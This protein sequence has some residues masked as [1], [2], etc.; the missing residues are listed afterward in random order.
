M[1]SQKHRNT[2]NHNNKHLNN[3]LNMQIKEFDFDSFKEVCKKVALSFKWI[4]LGIVMGL[5][6][7]TIGTGFYY[8]IRYATAL[9][10]A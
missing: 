4:I 5:L 8:G 3:H 6:V 7:G 9:R 1:S 10:S 2:K